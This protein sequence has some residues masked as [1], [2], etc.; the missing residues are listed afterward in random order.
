MTQAS[1]KAH[2][3]IKP[4][5]EAIKHMIIRLIIKNPSI[6]TARLQFLMHPTN[7]STVTARLSEL[8]D[9]GIIMPCSGSK[10]G[11]YTDWVI[12]PEESRVY[13][14]KR[15]LKAKFIKWMKKGI[16]FKHEIPNDFYEWIENRLK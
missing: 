9:E 6:D 1:I 13:V 16:E 12:V 11:A 10:I 7:E 8:F 15:R 3:D 5:K 2:E 14:S 4:N